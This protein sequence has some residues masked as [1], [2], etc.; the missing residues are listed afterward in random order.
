MSLV[1]WNDSEIMY[2]SGKTAT[3]ANRQAMTKRVVV[4]VRT[5]N[6]PG[7]WSAAAG[8][9]ASAATPRVRPRPGRG[10]AMLTAH[11]L[12]RSTRIWRMLSDEHDHRHHRRDRGGVAELEER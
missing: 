8:G 12:A 4:Q 11:R 5:P 9:V 6:S 1:G 10:G 2:S 7:S 3:A